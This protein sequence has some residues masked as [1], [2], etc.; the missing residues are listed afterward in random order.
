MA[1]GMACKGTIKLMKEGKMIGDK[2]WAR[3]QL[4][5]DLLIVIVIVR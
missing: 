3:M 1:Y 5:D 4:M 2:D